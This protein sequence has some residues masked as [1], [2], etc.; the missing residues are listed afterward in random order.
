MSF[1]LEELVDLYKSTGFAVI[2]WQRCVMLAVS[3]ILLY[4]ALK[5][6]FEPC[7]LFPLPLACF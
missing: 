4:L 6:N 7:C 5:K 1:I 3:C 2:T